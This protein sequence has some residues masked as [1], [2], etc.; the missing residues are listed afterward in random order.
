MNRR[1]A[2]SSISICLPVLLGARAAAPV[3]APTGPPILFEGDSGYLTLVPEAEYR[4]AM[5]KHRDDESTVP[6]R[7][8]PTGL[9]PKALFDSIL[10]LDRSVTLAVDEDSEGRRTLHVDLNGNGDLADDPVFPMTNRSVE[11]WDFAG[12]RGMKEASVADVETTIPPPGRPKSEGAPVRFRVAVTD[13]MVRIPG[14]PTRRRQALLWDSILR[15]GVLRLGRREVPFA[16]FGVGGRF[17]DDFNAVLFDLNR[18]GVM[19]PMR[20]FSDEY[21]WGW[22]KEINLAGGSYTFSVDPEGGSLTLTPSAKKLPERPS[23]EEGRPLPD[24]SFVDLEGKRRRLSDYR[25]RIV[26]VDFWGTWCPGCVAQTEELVAAYRKLHPL[27]FEILGVHS[28]GD[29]AE[30][31]K[32]IAAHAMRW[33]QTIEAGEAPRPPQ[34]LYRFLGAPN[35]FLVD[36]DGRRIAAGSN[37]LPDLIREAEKRL[38]SAD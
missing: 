23:L 37:S 31:R 2:V 30:V 24:F 34:K 32:F 3:V 17:D 36:K 28:G 29:E 15:K 35:Y 27:G 26:L 22:E 4:A 25:G 10:I 9:S 21:Y 16:L 33:P 11:L 38:G 7:A 14:E 6:L 20:R 13:E 18:D 12:G 19:D 8:S 5:E 1:I